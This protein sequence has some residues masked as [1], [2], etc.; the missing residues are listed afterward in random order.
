M[1]NLTPNLSDMCCSRNTLNRPL[2][3]S[4]V[5]YIGIQ[6]VILQ[7]GFGGYNP[8]QTVIFKKN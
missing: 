7:R 4:P 5:F 6:R 3:V 8:P 2:P 1:Y